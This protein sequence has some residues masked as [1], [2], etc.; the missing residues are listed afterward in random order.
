MIIDR[1]RR[2]FD[3]RPTIVHECRCC[4]AT[5]DAD[6]DDCPECGSAESNR[7]EIR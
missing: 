7:F 6:A 3:D 4:G 5:L 2:L 1:M